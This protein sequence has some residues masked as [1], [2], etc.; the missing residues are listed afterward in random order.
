MNISYK[1][2]SKGMRTAWANGARS[3]AQTI[4]T[5]MIVLLRK[6]EGVMVLGKT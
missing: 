6:V 3:V 1:L 2:P 5:K 4:A